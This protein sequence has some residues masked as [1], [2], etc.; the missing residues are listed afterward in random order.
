MTHRSDRSV[1]TNRHPQPAHRTA[2]HRR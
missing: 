2:R 1:Q